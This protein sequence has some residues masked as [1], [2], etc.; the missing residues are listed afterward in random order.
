MKTGVRE[1]VLATDRNQLVE[2]LWLDKNAL[3]VLEDPQPKKS[4]G[5]LKI[6]DLAGQKADIVVP[7]D[8][9]NGLRGFS[10]DKTLA[11]FEIGDG[12]GNNKVR[13]IEVASGKTVSTVNVHKWGCDSCLLTPDNKMLVTIPWFL[14]IPKS[15]F[16]WDLATGQ[17]KFTRK[18][19][20]PTATLVELSP[21][22]QTV[23]RDHAD[24]HFFN[25]R[26]KEF[27]ERWDAGQHGQYSRYTPRGKSFALGDREGFVKIYD[28]PDLK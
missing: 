12:N 27:V 22:G 19:R 18:L 13:V 25:L 14:E 7:C 17:E 21:D 2:A 4:A 23:T 20:R 8:G 6:I 10:Q 16:F 11:I 5:L 26:T 28:A 3:V 24:V 9:D 15:V 1:R